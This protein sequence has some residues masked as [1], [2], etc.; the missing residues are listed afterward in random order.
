[1]R[2]FSLSVVPRRGTCSGGC[3]VWPPRLA[4]LLVLAGLF[5]AATAA[6][7]R[8]VATKT[9]WLFQ[10]SRGTSAVKS[11]HHEQHDARRWGFKVP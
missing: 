6:A 7:A 4:G 3:P 8:L 9:G 1:V 2:S 11:D 10:P 5:V